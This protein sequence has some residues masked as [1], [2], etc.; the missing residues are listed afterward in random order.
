M[1]SQEYDKV[2]GRRF[3]EYLQKF[4]E[5]QSNNTNR[6]NRYASIAGV[7]QQAA[8]TSAQ[9]GQQAAGNVTNILSNDGSNALNAYSNIGSARGSG[10]VGSANAWTGAINGLTN[11]L[12]QYLLYSSLNPA[13]AANQ[14]GFFSTGGGR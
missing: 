13:N 14:P 2:Y 3:G 12:S 8:N 1:A 4:G 10:Y 9:V 11:N 7:G 5:F 6:F